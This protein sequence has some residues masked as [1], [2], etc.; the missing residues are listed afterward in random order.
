[1]KRFGKML[2]LVLIL[3]AVMSTIVAPASAASYPVMYLLYDISNP[4]IPQGETGVQEYMI[5]VAYANEAYFVELYDSAGNYV[6][7]AEDTYY[8]TSSEPMYV[9]ISIDTAALEMGVGTYTVYFGTAYHNGSDWYYS[10]NYYQYEIKVIANTCKGNHN[11][12]LDE[13]DTPGTCSEAGINRMK[14]TKCG[15]ITYESFWG[16]HSYGNWFLEDKVNHTHVCTLCGNNEIQS[17]TWGKGVTTKEPTCAEDGVITYTCSVCRGTKTETIPATGNHS[18]GDWFYATTEEHIHK[19]S[20][21]GKTEKQPHSY[22]AGV[23]TKEPTCN[24]EGVLLLTCQ[25]CGCTKE[26]ALPKTTNH[27]YGAGQQVDGD[28]HI[29]SCTLCGK[30][31][32]VPHIWEGGAYLEKPTLTASG[33]REFACA[34]CEA[35]KTDV[36]YP[37]TDGDLDG[38]GSVATED[39]VQLLLFISMPDIFPIGQ[40]NTDFDDNGR[41]TTEDAVQLLLHIS[42]PDIFPLYLEQ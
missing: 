35:T 4:T 38:S 39:V 20:T 12:K 7:S 8:N 17:H 3:A 41:T 16:D 13:V 24:E 37:L 29:H 27:S 36:V 40:V 28:T 30:E 2:V 11:M 6:A 5:E 22:D 26:E 23:I 33:S 42:M 31:E 18:Y 25:D 19:C 34:G 10:P 1:M 32:T 9:S 21:C 14:C 15:H